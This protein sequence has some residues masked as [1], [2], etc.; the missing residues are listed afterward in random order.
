M[1]EIRAMLESKEKPEDDEDEYGVEED[2]DEEDSSKE[3]KERL[4]SLEEKI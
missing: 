4:T 2:S 3:I 1:K